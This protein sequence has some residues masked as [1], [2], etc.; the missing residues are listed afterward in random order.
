MYISLMGLKVLASIFYLCADGSESPGLLTAFRHTA[1]F[2]K[3]LNEL[4][5]MFFHP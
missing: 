2:V 4:K 1:T 5:L 3:F